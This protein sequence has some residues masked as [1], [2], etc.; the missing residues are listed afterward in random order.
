MGT[1]QG[2]FP[3][4]DRPSHSPS[5]AAFHGKV[6]LLKM[7][8]KAPRTL[9]FRLSSVQGCLSTDT[10]HS[11]SGLTIQHYL[12]AGSAT[13][14]PRWL[15]VTGL[16]TSMWPQVPP[17]LPQAASFSKKAPCL[18]ILD[19]HH[20]IECLES[21]STGHEQMRCVFSIYT[22]SSLSDYSF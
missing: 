19:L 20:I 8:N 22:S 15:G 11:P 21:G 18:L 12:Q 17:S 5:K 2:R 7:I 14:H 4:S 13:F 9:T 10:L 3:N 6:T 1:P 16:V